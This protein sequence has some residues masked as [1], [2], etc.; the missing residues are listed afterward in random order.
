[1]PPCDCA[2]ATAGLSAM[3]ADVCRVLHAVREREHGA[4]LH[5]VREI[6]E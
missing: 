3:E 1:M 5:L 4:D 6:A 2:A